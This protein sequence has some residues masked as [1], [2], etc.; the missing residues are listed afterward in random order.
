MSHPNPRE[1]S[2]ILL[3]AADEGLIDWESL[4]RACIGYMSESSVKD[5]AESDY[6]ELCPEEEEDDT[7]DPDELCDECQGFNYQSESDKTVYPEISACSCGDDEDEEE[8]D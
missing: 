5:L 3:D 1:Y 4:A 6:D 7:P 2:T 8:E